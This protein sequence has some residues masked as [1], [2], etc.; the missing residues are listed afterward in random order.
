MINKTIWPKHDVTFNISGY[1]QTVIA[2]KELIK[3]PIR[4]ER[5]LLLIHDWTA[6]ITA[7][8][9]LLRRHPPYGRK[10][11]I[12]CRTMPAH[13]PNAYQPLWF[14]LVRKSTNGGYG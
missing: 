2:R 12:H 6:V 1:S 10:I 7:N 13:E 4:S 3:N 8:V 9:P 5:G 11:P 14:G